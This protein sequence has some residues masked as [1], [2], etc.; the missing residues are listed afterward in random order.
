MKLIF[1]GAMYPMLAGNLG[2]F[3]SGGI[4]ATIVT[5]IKPD[6]DFDWSQTQK[7]NPRGRALAQQNRTPE[8]GTSTAAS[9]SGEFDVE[10]KGE[11]DVKDDVQPA[12]MDLVSAGHHGED[13]SSLKRSFKI[14][15]YASTILTFITVFVSFSAI[16]SS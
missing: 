3:C 13:M 15:L 9:S 7:I 10:K 6:N 1:V 12:T 14:G 8:L 2:S 16:A 5:F 4:I 11:N